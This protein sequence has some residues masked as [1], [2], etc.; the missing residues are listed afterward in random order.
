VKANAFA[1]QNGKIKKAGDDEGF[2]HPRL[3]LLAAV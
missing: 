1:L 2:H 3:E